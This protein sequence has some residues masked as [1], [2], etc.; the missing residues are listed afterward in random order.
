M[1]QSFRFLKAMTTFSTQL[2]TGF[3]VLVVGAAYGGLSTVTNI[4]NLSS[5]CKQLNSPVAVAE[6]ETVP[7]HRPEIVILDERDGICM[8]LIPQIHYPS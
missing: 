3:R 4:L 6:L 2:S 8:R 1:R 5:G 7:K